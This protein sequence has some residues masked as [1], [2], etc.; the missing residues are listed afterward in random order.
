M[1]DQIRLSRRQVLGAAVAVGLGG[2]AAG[3]GTMAAFSD[4]ESSS[5]NA[6]QAG[7]LDLTLDGENQTVTF[8]NQTDVTPGEQ[9]SATVSLGNAGTIPG[10]PE[11]EVA[12]VSS[13]ENGFYGKENGQDGSPN[14]GELDEY[15]EIRASLDGTEIVGWTGADLLAEGQTYTASSTIQG[16]DSI[17]F[18]VEW[19]LP[20]DTS[21]MAQ[22]DGFS[23][24]LTF[25]LIQEG[26]A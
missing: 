22:S 2:T 3:A 6:V 18:T 26:H 24:D 10:V 25:R 5:D 23:F 4:T 7:T 9:G 12:G 15:L 17:P 1:T 20:N 16:G 11:I 21:N 19:R 8:L 14:D 13:T